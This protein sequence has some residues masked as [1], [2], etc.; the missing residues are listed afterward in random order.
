[1]FWPA[2]SHV[3]QQQGVSTPWNQLNRAGHFPHAMPIC[4]EN[5]FYS[6]GTLIS[7]LICLTL[8]LPNLILIR[9]S[10]KRRHCFGSKSPYKSE[11]VFMAIVEVQQ[12]SSSQYLW[13]AQVMNRRSCHWWVMDGHN[14][15]R[16]TDPLLQQQPEPA[17]TKEG[18]S[19]VPL[20]GF[21]VI[22]LWCSFTS[23]AGVRS[24]FKAN[25]V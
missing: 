25:V 1:M 18:L 15:S 8:Y 7:Y 22:L 13:S 21:T 3:P 6:T 14:F 4:N 16:A 11:F 9:I 23:Q 2:G 17:G 24:P 19:L 12:N 20:R 5:V 10:N